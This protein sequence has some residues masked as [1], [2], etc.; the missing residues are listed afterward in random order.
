VTSTPSLSP[1]ESLEPNPYDATA[2]GSGSRHKGWNWSST[3]AVMARV[4]E[5]RHAP[6]AVGPSRGFVRFARVRE[7][8]PIDGELAGGLEE[9]EARRFHD[10][11]I[12][13]YGT[14]AIASGARFGL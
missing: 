12:R 1:G 8:G 14:R 6:G 4:W 5:P 3:S 10:P 2:G 13:K 11:E 7:P 9:R